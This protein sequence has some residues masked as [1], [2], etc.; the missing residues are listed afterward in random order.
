MDDFRPWIRPTV[1]GPYL[2]TFGFVTLAHLSFGEEVLLAGHRLDSFLLAILTLGFYASALVVLLV[3]ADV[4]YLRWKWRKLPT[5][6]PAWISS[7]LAPVVTFGAWAS[8][9]WGDGSSI[10]ELFVR[11]VAP[12]VFSCFGLRAV[13]G[14]AP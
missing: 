9:G 4:T 8:W 11:I 6:V 14:S 7:M 13:L 3:I 12:M 5:G 1:L 10:P 2:T